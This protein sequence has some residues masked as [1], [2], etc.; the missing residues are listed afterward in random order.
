M[1]TINKDNFCR[2]E[3]KDA[4]TLEHKIAIANFIYIIKEENIFDTFVLDAKSTRSSSL[5]TQEIFHQIIKTEHLLH[6]MFDLCILWSSCRGRTTLWAQY[7]LI[8]ILLNYFSIRSINYD[9][10]VRMLARTEEFIPSN[11]KM[12]FTESYVNDF[13]GNRL[14]LTINDCKEYL[15]NLE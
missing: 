12:Y 7:N 15:K 9:L 1:E 10:A 5:N 2:Q 4:P 14:T 8:Q 11:K 3:Y 13:F 6:T